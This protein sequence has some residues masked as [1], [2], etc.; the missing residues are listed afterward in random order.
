M[1]VIYHNVAESIKTYLRTKWHPDL[2][3][4]LATND[5]DHGLYDRR[6]ACIRKPRNWAMVLCSNFRGE[7]NPHI[8]QCGLGQGLYLYQM[9]SWSIQLFGHNRRG[10]RYTDLR[11]SVSRK[12]GEAAPLLY[13]FRWGGAVSPFNIMSP[14]LRATSVPGG[15]LINTVVWSQ[16][17]RHGPRFI[18]TQACHICQSGWIARLASLY[19][20]NST[21][22]CLVVLW[23]LW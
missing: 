12:S 21:F 3:S 8:T 16:Y 10:P 17:N 7:L 13:P 1:V 23:L 5:I 6:L 15:I 22:W 19:V 4:H 11:H 2:S 18:R 9:A 20:Y 14:G